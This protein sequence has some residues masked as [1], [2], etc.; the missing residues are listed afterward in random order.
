M[1]NDP[2]LYFEGVK[3]KKAASKTKLSIEQIL[4]IEA[5]TLDVDS[6]LWNARNAFLFSFYSGGN[7]VWG[8]LLPEV[9]KYCQR[10]AYVYDE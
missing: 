6:W 8:Y 7:P 2:F 5:L 4:G 9:V 1:S 10:P 3:R